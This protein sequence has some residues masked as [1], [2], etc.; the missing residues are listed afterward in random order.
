MKVDCGAFKGGLRGVVALSLLVWSIGSCV[1]CFAQFNTESL[2]SRS[3]PTVAEKTA[4]T[5]TAT[6][7]QVSEFL[8]LLAEG[9]A[10][11]RQTSIGQTTE[12]RPLDAIILA[13]E[14]NVVLPLPENDPRLTV[15]ILGGIHSG[16]CDSKEAILALGRDWL[17]DS[18]K[19]KELLDSMVFI[20]VPN[21]NADGNERVGGLHRP[22]Q[23][24]PSLGMGTRE[25]AMGLDLNRDFVKLESPE[26]R[27]LVRTLDAWDVDVL[28]DAHTTNGSLHQYDLTYDIPHN[29]AAHPKLQ[30]WMRD[31]FLPKVTM[32]L[33]SKGL[34]TFYYGNFSADYKRWES[35]GHELRY[36]TEYM[37]ARGKIGILV[38]SYSYA[39]YQRRVEA[40]YQFIDECVRQLVDDREQVR[41]LFQSP[42][43]EDKKIPIQG[44]IVSAEKKFDVKAYAWSDKP[45]A[46]PEKE[47]DVDSAHRDGTPKATTASERGPFP[48]PRDRLK[49]DQ[50]VGRDYSVDLINV[51][52]SKLQVDAPEFYFV[53]FE[54][55]WAAGR[56]RLHGIELLES[57]DPRASELIDVSAYRIR[58]IREL[59][60]FQGH[61]IKRRGRGGGDQS[62]LGRGLVGSYFAVA[63]SL[64]DMFT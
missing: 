54:H 6:G 20:L 22:G 26:V 62:S 25:N 28:F 5:A 17:A 64:S 4:F 16:E 44:R 13:K 29:P 41:A 48:T 57:I 18:K 36:S 23:D 14:P 34:P 47:A 49:K 55:A 35:F 60:E 10:E 46:K 2:S 40:S 7:P 24:G 12:R 31:T 43:F 30:K 33:E 59:P 63:R 50:L 51:G 8:A 42:P 15:L 39:T 9:H 21:F 11:A 56:L 52:E 1:S 37:G 32:Q 53:P 38:E 61:A 19:K 45:A 58:S 27:S 3:L